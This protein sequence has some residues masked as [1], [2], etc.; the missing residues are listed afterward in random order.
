MGKAMLPL[1]R[2]RLFCLVIVSQACSDPSTVPVRHKRFILPIRVALLLMLKD[3]ASCFIERDAFL[4][5]SRH[6][7]PLFGCA[8]FA[9]D[10]GKGFKEERADSFSPPVRVKIKDEHFA[11]ICAGHAAADCA[12]YGAILEGHIPPVPAVTSIG[13]FTADP[14]GM[15]KFFDDPL[16]IRFRMAFPV[17]RTVAAGTYIGNPLHVLKGRSFY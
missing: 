8:F 6:R 15:I 7:Y 5:P 11:L 3:E 9:L 2:H 16:D 4:I 1:R 17:G 13:D 12:E 14:V 10:S